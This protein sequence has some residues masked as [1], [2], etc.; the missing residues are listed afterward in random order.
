VGCRE[1]AYGILVGS[2]E[3]KRPLVRPRRG[4]EDDIKV[5]LKE[6]DWAA[7]TGSGSG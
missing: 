2:H 1:G 4:W 3:G 5:D 6:V 7:W